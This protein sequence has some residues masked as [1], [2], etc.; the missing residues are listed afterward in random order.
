[1]K[2]Q[3]LDNV[4]RMPSCLLACM[5]AEYIYIHIM[6]YDNNVQLILLFSELLIKIAAL[7]LIDF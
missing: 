5:H 6:P 2:N 1:M 7:F 3:W 4:Q